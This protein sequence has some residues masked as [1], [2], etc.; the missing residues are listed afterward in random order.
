MSRALGSRANPRYSAAE[1]Y[2]LSWVV[3]EGL[4]V[5]AGALAASG[6]ITVGVPRWLA[7][8][9][10]GAASVL[11]A[12]RALDMSVPHLNTLLNRQARDVASYERSL[13]LAAVNVFEVMLGVAAV[14]V[15]W[16]SWSVATAFRSAFG[17]AILRG[18][19]PSSDLAAVTPDYVGTLLSVL[20]LT[21]VV[22]VVLGL[23]S[24]HRFDELTR[25]P[26]VSSP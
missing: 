14:L 21:A 15:I 19:I 8:S 13:V 22:G 1:I 20:I 18:P 23:I 6:A 24:S 4:I 3:I 7:L 17:L 9:A 25:E 2:V 26:A 16:S 10:A 12:F 5:A 11:L